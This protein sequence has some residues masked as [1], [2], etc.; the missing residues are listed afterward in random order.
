MNIVPVLI[1][2]FINNM[3]DIQRLNE[4]DEFPPVVIFN[5]NRNAQEL[6]DIEDLRGQVLRFNELREEFEDNHQQLLEMQRRNVFI[7]KMERV[8]LFLITYGLIKSFVHISY[9]LLFYYK[10]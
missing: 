4:A 6:D 1:M 9:S 10:L 2:P 3:P 5:Q 7:D 8:V